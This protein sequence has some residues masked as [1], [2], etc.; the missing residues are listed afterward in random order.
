MT[1]EG[2]GI[3][4]GRTCRVRLH[5]ATGAIRFRR[6]AS[7]IPADVRHVVATER[8]TTL[9]RDGH[10]VAMV[11][12]LLAG[13]RIAGW[14][15]NV[16]VE[17]DADELPILDGSAAPWHEAIAELGTPPPAPPSL[18]PETPI[19]VGRGESSMVWEPGPERVCAEIA[20]DHP[21]IGHQAWCGAPEDLTDVVFARTFGFLADADTLR[22]N[23]LALGAS[24]ERAIVFAE[25]GP[26]EPL[27]VPDEPVRHK[28]LDLV[29]DLALLGRPL[30]G[31]IT[32]IRGSHAL[33][34]A[35]MG[36]LR[37]HLDASTRRST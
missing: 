35:F 13:L 10:R 29:G 31:S 30:G 37:T 9:G 25:T 24:T 36:H 33:H 27:R 3:H 20:F 32:A 34:I 15:R 16:I 28:V 8:C 17:V 1:V 23:G 7:E 2:V 4:S 12:H 22:R 6:G 18:H 19:T 14:W 5:R 11:E 26:L 21:A